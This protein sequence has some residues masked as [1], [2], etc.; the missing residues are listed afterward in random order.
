MK[1]NLPIRKTLIHVFAGFLAFTLLLGQVLA[2]TGHHE[3]EEH[4]EEGHVELTPEQIEPPVAR[5]IPE[6]AERVVR[7]VKEWRDQHHS[8]PGHD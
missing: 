2:E 3:E 6:A 8:E 5:A 4:G 1:S 7:L